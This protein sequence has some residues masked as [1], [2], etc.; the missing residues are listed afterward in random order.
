MTALLESSLANRSLISIGD[1][2]KEEIVAILQ[3][4][5][6]LKAK[7]EPTL[8]HGLSMGSCFFEPST[9]TRLSF[10]RAM[11]KLG[12]TVVG[13]SD[14]EVTSIKKGESLSDSIRIMSSYV[15]LLV[16]RHPLEGSA[17]LAAETA[18]I[19]VI[20]GGDGS[21]QHPTQTL[22]DLF[23]IEE[24]HGTLDKLSIGMVGDLKYGR[25]VHSLA[26]ACTHFDM[27]LYFVCP[28]HLDLPEGVCD[29]LRRRGIKF[30]FHKGIDQV[31]SKID[32]LYMTR[33]QKERF[34]H[35]VDVSAL[36]SGFALTAEL[37]EQARP[38]LKVLHPLPRCE[39]IPPAIDTTPFAY[40]FQQAE[41]GLYVRQALLAMILGKL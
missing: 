28:P 19:P 29:D 30:S 5:K 13:F 17:R 18:S 32:I 41:N 27:R 11:Q 14:E 24:C 35:A 12:G 7:P 16:I 25:T 8:L 22:L 33:L 20:N 21:N 36:S 38:H 37:L 23:T 6:R 2:S 40:Y 1:L 9:R 26:Q 15:D 39:E 34:A 31:I 4:A 3:L 10:E